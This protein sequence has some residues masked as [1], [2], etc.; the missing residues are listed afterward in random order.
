M[1]LPGLILLFL[2]SALVASCASPPTTP[3]GPPANPAP[4]TWQLDPARA[5]RDIKIACD[6]WHVARDAAEVAG[7][8]VPGVSD[9]AILIGDFADPACAGAIAIDPAMPAKIRADTAK[10]RSLLGQPA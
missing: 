5:Q 6:G 1:K 9:A 2:A 4:E 3:G 8:F 10:L 7:L